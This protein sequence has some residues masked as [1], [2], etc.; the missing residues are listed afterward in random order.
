MKKFDVLWRSPAEPADRADASTTRSSFKSVS[1]Q[2]SRC[3]PLKEPLKGIAGLDKFPFRHL[4][5][6]TACIQYQPLNQRGRGDVKRRVIDLRF[7]APLHRAKAPRRRRP[8]ALFAAQSG[9]RHRSERSGRKSLRRG[10]ISGMPLI[11]PAPPEVRRWLFA[12][13]PLYQCSLPPPT[14]HPCHRAGGHRSVV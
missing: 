4:V 12:T 8:L 7:A 13:S 11:S 3:C 10:D 2:A 6:V 1:D 9:L 14:R 5:R